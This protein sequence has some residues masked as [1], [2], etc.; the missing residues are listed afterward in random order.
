MGDALPVVNL[1]NH[2]VQE[3]AAGQSHTCVLLTLGGVA[4]WGFNQYG[5]VIVASRPGNWGWKTE[6]ADLW[7]RQGTGVEGGLALFYEELAIVR[8]CIKRQYNTSKYRLVGGRVGCVLY[9]M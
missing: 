8:G 2:T 4:C 3:V 1:G 6:R 9:G 5:Q 7:S